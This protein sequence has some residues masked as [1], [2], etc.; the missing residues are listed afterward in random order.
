MIPTAFCQ[1]S[2][3]V[4]SGNGATKGPVPEY[5]PPAAGLAAVDD[6]AGPMRS[7]EASFSGWFMA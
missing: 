6:Y 4:A 7:N 2:P 3:P 5:N 1:E